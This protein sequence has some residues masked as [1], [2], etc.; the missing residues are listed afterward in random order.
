MTTI[1]DIPI[2]LAAIDL[3]ASNTYLI[4]DVDA[5]TN[6]TRKLRVSSLPSSTPITYI[7]STVPSDNSTIGLYSVQTGAS[8]GLYVSSGVGSPYLIVSYQEDGT[9]PAP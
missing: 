3:D 7:E 8:R 9:W 4:V 5:A 6:V 1:L 2:E